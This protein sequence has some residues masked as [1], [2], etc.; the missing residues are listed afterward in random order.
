MIFCK[1]FRSCTIFAL[2][3]QL[4]QNRVNTIASL[5]MLAYYAR[6]LFILLKVLRHTGKSRQPACCQMKSRPSACGQEQCQIIWSDIFERVV[7]VCDT[8]EWKAGYQRAATMKS[9]LPASDQQ[10]FKIISRYYLPTNSVCRDDVNKHLL[11]YKRITVSLHL[12]R[13]TRCWQDV[14]DEPPPM[15]DACKLFDSSLRSTGPSPLE[16]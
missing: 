10:Q 12:T 9:R 13:Q 2:L 15:K 1:S 5:A 6:L 7:Y 8:V 11:G 4:T 16:C 14:D 3:R